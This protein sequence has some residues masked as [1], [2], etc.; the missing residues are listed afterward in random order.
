MDLREAAEALGVHYQTAYAT[1]AC[2]AGASLVVLSSAM[3]QT[4][5]QAQ[6]AAQVITA[7]SPRLTVLAGRPADSLH[8]L[9]TRAATPRTAGGKQHA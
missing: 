7:A 6:Q 4:A 1:F 8:D 3:G 9:L 2:Q 5:R